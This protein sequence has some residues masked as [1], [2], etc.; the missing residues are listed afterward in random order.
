MVALI[1][2]FAAL[3]TNALLVVETARGDSR[4][5]L[6][7]F[8]ALTAGSAWAVFAVWR[9]AV[10]IPAPKRVAAALVV[11]S[12]IAIANFGYQNLYQLPA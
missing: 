1:G 12:A 7:L 2:A 9:T 6:A 11:S 5:Y 8:V 3:L 10:R 4:A